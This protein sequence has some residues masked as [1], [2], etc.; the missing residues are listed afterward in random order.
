M[1]DNLSITPETALKTLYTNLYPNLSEEHLSTPY[2]TSFE[3]NQI[4]LITNP[5]VSDAREVFLAS[6]KTAVELEISYRAE[7][8]QTQTT[9]TRLVVKQLEE[10]KK[11]AYKKTTNNLN[12]Y[13]YVV[14]K[15]KLEPPEGP[16]VS[17]ESIQVAN[18]T[19]KDYITLLGGDNQSVHTL[20][21]LLHTVHAKQR[22]F[23]TELVAIL[24]REALLQHVQLCKSNVD[25][26]KAKEELEKRL[27]TKKKKLEEVRKNNEKTEQLQTNY[28]LNIKLLADYYTSENYKTN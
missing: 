28:D 23:T 4:E 27:K 2:P 18:K 3:E 13:V 25:L 19:L 20:I 1:T 26:G 17:P 9:N 22:E 12:L 21:Q 24:Q 10:K 11:E 14:I 5:T 8:T 15:D 6:W 16:V 7:V